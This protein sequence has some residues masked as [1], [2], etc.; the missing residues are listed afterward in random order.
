MIH[1]Y[2]PGQVGRRQIEILKEEGVPLNRV[3]LDHSNDTTDLEYLFWIL[4]QGCFLGLDRYPGTVPVPSPGTRR[5]RRWSTPVCRPCLHLS[6]LVAGTTHRER[7]PYRDAR[8]PAEDES[9]WVSVHPES[10]LSAVEGMGHLTESDR[11]AAGRWTEELLRGQV[12]LRRPRHDLPVACRVGT[13][14]PGR[15]HLRKCAS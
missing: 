3:K 7:L 4:D 13:L 15:Q 11:H 6:R 1:S 12:I 9:P 8:T 14:E 10:R 2:S 5:S